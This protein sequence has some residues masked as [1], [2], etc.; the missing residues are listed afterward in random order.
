M[1]ALILA[2]M[3]HFGQTHAND[4]LDRFVEE[5][6]DALLAHDW[7]AFSKVAA[8]YVSIEKHWRLYKQYLTSDYREQ[9]E[10]DAD[11]QTISSLIGVANIDT[12]KA[13]D[14]KWFDQFCDG[15]KD[16]YDSY[17]THY[18]GWRQTYGQYGLHGGD[19]IVLSEP[20]F[21]GKIASNMTF[22]VTFGRLNGRYVCERLILEGH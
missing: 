1:V 19:S 9:N 10:D 15:V 21:S 5:A 22:M 13:R 12:L 18:F 7:Q 4:E 8:P 20:H 2:S 11:A 16:A 17:N 3:L 14:R 6:S